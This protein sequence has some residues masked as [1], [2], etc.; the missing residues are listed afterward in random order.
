MDSST[1]CVKTA[2]KTVSRT[3]R[4]ISREA[5]KEGASAGSDGEP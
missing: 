4:G 1:S 3:E 5:Q 2:I